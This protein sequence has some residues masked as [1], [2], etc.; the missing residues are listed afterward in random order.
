VSSMPSRGHVARHSFFPVGG[1]SG[2]G[3]IWA[4]R[5]RRGWRA[6]AVLAASGLAACGA[7]L[8][9]AD[10][11][12]SSSSGPSLDQL[13]AKANA[14]SQQIDT[15]S[16]QFDGMKI[17]LAQ[18][19][20][21]VRTAR[22][23]AARDAAMLGQDQNYIAS[24]AVESYM[25]GGLSPSLQLLQS[26]Q[27][28]TMLSRASIMTQLAAE[29]GAKVSLVS[30]AQTAALRATAAADQE[31]QRAKQL[32]HQITATENKL[33]AKRNLFD[34]KAFAQAVAVY[35]QTGHY[36]DVPVAGDSLGVR[37]L[38]EALS[39]IGKPYVWGGASPSVGFDCSGLV[40]WAY[41]QEGISLEHFTGDL[42]NE[43]V[44]VPES[45]LEPGDLVF[46]YV[47]I[48]HVG[49][50]IG[51][52]LMVDAPTFGQDV[53]IQPISDDPYVGGGYVPTA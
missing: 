14:L 25:S 20:A 24:I 21:E 37:A 45:Q 31:E 42:W 49:I 16:Q 11:H 7:L 17:Q 5:P 4:R 2:T 19:Q 28:Q 27:P 18:A 33:I 41:A 34:S 1:Q 52:G 43:V 53:Q 13:V 3:R 51:K 6:C 44:H 46:F 26:S 15:L 23:N 12:A 39:M 50:Y 40:V 29:N 22:Q 9:A 36:P 30:T 8:P 32:Q 35:D 10:A 38:N 48:S 47:G